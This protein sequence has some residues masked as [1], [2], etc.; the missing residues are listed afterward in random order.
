MPAGSAMARI[1]KRGYLIAGVDQ[2]IYLDS[3]RNPLN[4]QLEGFDIGVARQI[5]QAIF[6]NPRPDRVQGDHV[7]AA[8]PRD[9]ERG[10][11]H[12]R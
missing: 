3:Y 11:R 1:E 10:G 6:G 8:D 12:R 9:T 2:T 4:G 7:R 5:A